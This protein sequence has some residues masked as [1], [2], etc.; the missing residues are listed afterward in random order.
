MLYLPTAKE[1]PNQTH[2]NKKQHFIPP[3]RHGGTRPIRPPP[4]AG[5]VFPADD[6]RLV[7]IPNHI[8]KVTARQKKKNPAA[9][10]DTP[11]RCVLGPGTFTQ[12]AS[13]DCEWM[14][15]WCKSVARPPPVCGLHV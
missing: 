5:L 15:G 7:V 14:F 13:G 1:C 3:H 4:S 10:S 9:S 8:C 12:V 6:D 2:L 11:C